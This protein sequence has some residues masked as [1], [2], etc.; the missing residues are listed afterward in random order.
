VDRVGPSPAA[1][2]NAIA[3]ALPE[4]RPDPVLAARDRR[5]P[6]ACHA[7]D[8]A[9]LLAGA[10]GSAGRDRPADQPPLA[11]VGDGAVGPVKAAD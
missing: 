2:T 1:S 11:W 4:T 6:A 10:P 7:C 8:V 3:L 5:T 9:T